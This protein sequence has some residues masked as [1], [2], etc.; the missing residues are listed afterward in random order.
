[1]V[2]DLDGV[3]FL[4]SAGLRALFE[5]N[6]F[7]IRECRDLRVIRKLRTG[8]WRPPGCGNT[9]CL[10]KKYHTLPYSKRAEPIFTALPERAWVKETDVG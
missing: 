5:V 3:R 4:S 2:V 1:M 6:K 9:S 7:A 10:L 8:R